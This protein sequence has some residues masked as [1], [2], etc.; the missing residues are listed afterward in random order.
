[1][2]RLKGY[3]QNALKGTCVHFAQCVEEIHEQLPLS[4]EDSQVVIVSESLENIKTNRQFQIRPKYIKNALDWLMIN[5]ILYVE[6]IQRN[7]NEKEYL[8]QLQNILIIPNGEHVSQCASISKSVQSI[9]MPA[10]KPSTSSKL[11]N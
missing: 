4:I 9:R 3:G 10:V 11:I 8:E 7:C 2:Y 5:N 6:V 1:M